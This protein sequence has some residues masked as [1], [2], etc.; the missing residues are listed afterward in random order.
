[1]IITMKTPRAHLQTGDK[2]TLDGYKKPLTVVVTEGLT[3]R[4]RTANGYS[5]WT[6]RKEYDRVVT[7]VS[8]VIR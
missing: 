3:T 2:V 7:K 1:M 8:E 6:I 5:V 4:L